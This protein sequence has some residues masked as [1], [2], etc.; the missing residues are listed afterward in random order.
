MWLN[1]I[2]KNIGNRYFPV[3]TAENNKLQNN[4]WITNSGGD[5]TRHLKQQYFSFVFDFWS[6][7]FETNIGVAH[8]C[9]RRSININGVKSRA[10]FDEEEGRKPSEMKWQRKVFI[11]N[12]F[13]TLRAKLNEIRIN[14]MFG[15]SNCG[16]MSPKILRK[17]NTFFIYTLT[18][19]HVVRSFRMVSVEIYHSNTGFSVDFF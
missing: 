8:W 15:R 13:A 3:K 5:N 16:A 7:L 9:R 2:S 10:Y 17:L 19:V 12:W 6:R 11:P 18:R 1:V 4:K 14:D